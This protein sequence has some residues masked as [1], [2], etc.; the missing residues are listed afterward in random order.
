MITNHNH[1]QAAR[2]WWDVNYRSNKEY[3]IGSSPFKKSEA[4]KAEWEAIYRSFNIDP[5]RCPKIVDFGCGNGYFALNFL[6]RGFDVTGIDVSE[7]ALE[8]LTIRAHKY[9]LSKG[10]HL[11]NNGLY[12]PMKRLDGAFDAGY[13]IVTYHCIPQEEQ[14]NAFRNFIRLVKKGGK[15]LI[16]EP[17]PL[18]PLF[19]LYYLFTYKNNLSEAG[20]IIHSRKDI[21]VDLFV[22][23][24][25]NNIK[26]F[27][28]SFLPTSL[29]NR[30]GFVRTMNRILCKLPF[31]NTFAAFHIITA[32]KQ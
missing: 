20:N 18:N 14:K 4:R 8:L 30:W 3:I 6:K 9:N 13:M 21:L 28:H 26:I 19:Y 1:K 7:E 12:A 24:G 29:I 15:I 25:L 23:N 2:K 27:R 31:I 22:E 5:T 32:V 16:M 17:N 10:L 11:I